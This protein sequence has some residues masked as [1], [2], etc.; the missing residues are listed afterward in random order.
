MKQKWEIATHSLGQPMWHKKK[1]QL[2]AKMLFKSN[3]GELSM[4]EKNIEEINKT[5]KTKKSR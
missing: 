2:D 1:K 5:S 4:F 3:S